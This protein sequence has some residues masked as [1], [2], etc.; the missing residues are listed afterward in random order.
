MD[1]K[2]KIKVFKRLLLVTQVGWL[3]LVYIYH[4]T[5]RD[6]F[7]SNK[8]LYKTAI[9]LDKAVLAFLEEADP[10]L[11]VKVAEISRIEG[12]FQDIVGKIRD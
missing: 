10:D 9:V 4:K 5:L 3:A 11:I 12:S 1:D 8:E 2:T 6:Y 7:D